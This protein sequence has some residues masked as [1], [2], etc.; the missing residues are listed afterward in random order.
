M[1]MT[2]V[3]VA[4]LDGVDGVSHFEQCSRM[5]LLRLLSHAGHGIEVYALNAKVI[6]QFK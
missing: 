4:I 2:S 1:K 3:N 6:L 5:G